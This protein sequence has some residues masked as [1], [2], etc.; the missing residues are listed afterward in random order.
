MKI[1]INDHRKL[2]SINDEFRTAYPNLELA[3]FAKPHAPGGP[4]FP[5]SVSYSKSV[6]ECRTIHNAGD[7]ELSDEMTP[8]ALE[9]QLRDIFGLTASVIRKSRKPHE[10]QG[11]GTMTL[12][13]YS[14]KGK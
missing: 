11:P 13:E 1:R 4:T 3:F 9:E 12:R 2:F 5:Q 8:A 14:E 10:D 7:L 6:T